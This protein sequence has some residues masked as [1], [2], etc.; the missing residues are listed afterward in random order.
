MGKIRSVVI[1]GGFLGSLAAASHSAVLVQQN[2][3]ATQSPDQKKEA[4]SDYVPKVENVQIIEGLTEEDLEEEEYYDSLE[5]LALMVEAEAGNQSIEGKKLVVDVALN[6]V[7]SDQ[8]PDDLTEVITELNAFTSYW[9]GGIDSVWEASP[10]TY[11]AIREE[12]EH[13]TNTEVLYFTSEGYSEY[14]TAW[15]KVGD[16]YFSKK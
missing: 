11:E 1:L 9:D 13:R 12:L 15:K 4:A 7:D 16:H 14:G 6:R 3:E 8:F 2:D 5:L 10:S